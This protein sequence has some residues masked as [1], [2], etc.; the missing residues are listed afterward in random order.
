MKTRDGVAEA[1]IEPGARTLCEPWPRGPELNRWRLIVPWKPLPMPM[2]ATLTLSPGSK[3][4]TVTVSPCDGAVDAA[5]E[6]DEAAVGAEAGLREVPELGLRELPLGDRV[7]RELHG[8]VAVGVDGLHLHDRA[9]TGLDHGD[10]RH[11]TGLRVEDL[12]HA[13]LLAEDSFAMFFRA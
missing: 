11:R 12:R 1:P 9:R 4:S 7:E 6:L 3:S 10:G 5:A 13:E 2:P 8:V